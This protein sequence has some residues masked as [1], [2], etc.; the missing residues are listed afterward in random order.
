MAATPSAAA[1]SLTHTL[2]SMSDDALATL[3]RQ[4]PDL[5]VPRPGDMA[6]LAGRSRTAMS[7]SRALDLLDEP[8]LRVLDGLRLAAD[9]PSGEAPVTSLSALSGLLTDG[10]D[11][12]A[13]V[14]RLRELALLWGPDDRLRFPASVAE[15]AGPY[16][17]GLGRP[18]AEL[19][20]EAAALVSDSAALRRAVMAAPPAA[21]AVLDRL[22][23][24][25]PIGTVANA[26]DGGTEGDS[27]VRWLI[28]RH[29]LV[30]VAEDTV[31][32]PRELGVLLRRDTGPLGPLRSQPQPTTDGPGTHAVDDFAAAR[33]MEVVGQ[34]EAVFTS[35]SAEPAPEIKSGGIGMQRLHR[36]ARD[37][38]LTDTEAALL[39]EAGYAA[40][41]LGRDPGWLPSSAYDGWLADDTAGRWTVLARAWL[42]SPR[43][44]RLLGTQPGRQ[45]PGTVLSEGLVSRLAPERRRELLHLMAAYP[46]GTPL[47]PEMLVR[48]L[49]WR[50]PRRH[51]EEMIRAI[52]RQAAFLGVIAV[53]ALTDHGRQLI[54]EPADDDPLGIRAP[55]TDPVVT[56]L[57]DVLPE[58][59]D[60]LIVQSDLSV[61]V[62]GPPSVLLAA[63]LSLVT[64][65]ESQ[66]VHRITENS[67][68]RALDAGYSAEDIRGLFTRRARGELPQTLG[69]LIG[70]VARR[71][72]GLRAGDAGGYLRSED[73]AVLAQL[74][75]DR[76]LAPLR[77]RQLAPSVL[78]SRLP[79]ADLVDA[80]R[81]AGYSPVT[82]D[83]TGDIVIDRRVP[84]RAR[85]ADRPADPGDPSPRVDGA[86]LLA[87]IEQLRISDARAPR[88]GGGPSDK[89]RESLERAVPGREP[90]WVEY[91][92]GR[93]EVVRRLLRP[94]S[95]SAGYLRAEDR[96]TDMLHTIAVSAIR[97]VTVVNV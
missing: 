55:E 1:E 29:L 77:L 79:L 84:P 16:P 18:A 88:D 54:R 86:P 66:A 62:P 12:T 34:A 72:G 44:V 74:L 76:R 81:R 60:H 46:P 71:H 49:A 52:H 5:A 31:E 13:A 38:G 50:R 70:D 19:G 92:D 40:G 37:T 85:T 96:R 35:L 15:A 48:I 82:E 69:Y 17:A 14:A 41:L 89:V 39:L 7:V 45:R 27:P 28:G 20:E 53:D 21:R 73:P 36:I 80:L 83:D 93:G 11:A 10:G 68:R 67:I 51:N 6:A 61:V 78:V 97:S 63:E 22:A 58:P 24:G 59:V 2:R 9:D 87:L 3:L 56:V 64:E 90:V 8:T 43:D 32:L 30:P 57:R 33:V 42:D 4:R 47:S 91:T 95:L 23:E 65:P 25:P 75:G 26:L 94:V